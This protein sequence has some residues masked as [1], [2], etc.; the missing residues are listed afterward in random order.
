MKS[1]GNIQESSSCGIITIMAALALLIS[2]FSLASLLQ[3]PTN[4]LSSLVS[5]QFDTY[6]P[7]NS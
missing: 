2:L 7:I 1:V 3:Q 6:C 5:F 4:D